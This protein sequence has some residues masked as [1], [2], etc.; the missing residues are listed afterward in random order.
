M[1]SLVLLKNIIPQSA[2]SKYSECK[3]HDFRTFSFYS[4]T[5]WDFH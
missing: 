3:T 5:R 2:L 4:V 1:V